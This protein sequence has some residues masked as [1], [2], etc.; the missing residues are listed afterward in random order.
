MNN[1]KILLAAFTLLI[2]SISSQAQEVKFS[3][4]YS[5]DVSRPYPVVDG[6]VKDYIP[7]DDK[8]LV[9][10]KVD[11]EEVILQ[12]FDA[13]SM[14]QV[15]T[16]TYKDFPKY[17]KFIDVQK[18][19]DKVFYI[20]HTYDKKTKRF[21]I[22]QREISTARGTFLK[23][24]KLVTTSRA[25]RGSLPSSD[26]T[27]TKLTTFSWG[28]RGDKFHV[29]KSYDES[30]ILI[31]YN[32]TPKSKKDKINKDE[33]GLYVYDTNMEE[34]WGTEVRLP[35]TE[36]Q[37][38]NLA[39]AV[40]NKGEVKMFIS[41]NVKK[42][43]ELYTVDDSKVLKEHALGISSKMAARDFKL[44]EDASG[45]FTCIAF[46]ANGLEYKFISNSISY[47]A[48]GLLYFEVDKDNKVQNQKTF[49]FSKTFIMQ[50]LSKGQ[51]KRVEKREK[52]GKAG[53]L[54][55]VLRDVIVQKDGS[56][57][58]AGERQYVVST[59]SSASVG[60]ISRSSNKYYFTNMVI[61]K[62]SA[63]R[64]LDWIKKLPKNQM[65][66]RGVGQMSYSYLQGKD[67]DYLAYVDNPKNIGLKADDGVPKA[68]AD[69]KGGFLT[70]YKVNKATG[71]L[72]KHTLLDLKKL[73]KGFKAYQFSTSRIVNLGDGV[74][75]METYIKGK[76]DVMVKFTIN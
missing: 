72:E 17:M 7:L 56:I 14:K 59:S 34:I 55:L 33:V 36:A 31:H 48:N 60:G 53:I 62:L 20:Y 58:I 64:E 39:Y 61:M 8:T 43:Y 1:I 66:V 68:H 44:Q 23:A 71:N 26:M 5:V 15:A 37:I 10:L 73:P 67:A 6:S 3:R 28:S 57:I 40:S 70:T 54:D 2:G 42:K 13:T 50:N 9:M 41:N 29:K 35:K 27:K 45:K 25:V 32:L 69:G 51:K 18:L 4:D 12:K 22:Y 65:G 21:S 30:K 74:F 47:N 52:K 75:L 24:K 16:K 11:G 63:N 76:E 38:N 46:Y 19:G 49:D